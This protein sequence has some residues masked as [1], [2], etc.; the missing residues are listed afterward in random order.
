[1]SRTIIGFALE[2]NIELTEEVKQLAK[3]KQRQNN[4]KEKDS[5]VFLFKKAI[6]E[7]IPKIV[8]TVILILSGMII[9]LFD[10]PVLD[11]IKN[12]L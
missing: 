7:N 6:K 12:L 9:E 2:N 1:M 10:L 11:T 4:E 8:S 3:I 5:F